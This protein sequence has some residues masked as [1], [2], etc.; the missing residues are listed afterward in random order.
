M[1]CLS[2]LSYFAEFRDVVVIS[3]ADSGILVEMIGWGGWGTVGQRTHRP[4]MVG[5]S[6]VGNSSIGRFLCALRC[7]CQVST[8]ERNGQQR[9]EAVGH[10]YVRVRFRT[11]TNSS[12]SLKRQTS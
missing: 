5:A 8:R 12:T 9:N 4:R 1:V 6:K 3:A 2:A 10:T 11:L 7:A